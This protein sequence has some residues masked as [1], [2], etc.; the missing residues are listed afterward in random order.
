MDANLISLSGKILFVGIGRSDSPGEVLK[1]DFLLTYR[2]LTRYKGEFMH[3]TTNPCRKI[4]F[5]CVNLCDPQP[6]R[7]G[8][9][10]C[11]HL[12]LPQ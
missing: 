4:E 11:S 3:I 10:Q 12:L 1:D 9:R 8:P 2:N 6:L 7:H 5:E